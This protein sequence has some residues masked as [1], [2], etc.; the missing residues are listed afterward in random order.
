[1]EQNREPRNKA[2]HLWSVNLRQ[3]RQ[4]YKMGK[5]TVSLSGAGKTGPAACESVKL[6]HT[7]T[8]CT[9]INSKQLKDLNIRQD[10]IILLEEKVGK[11]L[12]DINCINVCLGQSPK[13]RELKTKISQ[14]DLIKL[15]GFCTAKEPVKKKQQQKKTKDNLLNGRKQ[16]QRC[17]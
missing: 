12:S 15:T 9:E 16:F 11:T 1:M 5:K 3:R 14:W 10:I 4:E 7:L 6:E 8:P 13:A 17:N 2:T